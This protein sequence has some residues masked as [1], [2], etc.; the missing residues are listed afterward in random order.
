MMFLLCHLMFNN[1]IRIMR[2]S[3]TATAF[4]PIHFANSAAVLLV[5]VL[6]YYKQFTFDS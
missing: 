1:D 4:V 2:M 3:A 6:S 5:A